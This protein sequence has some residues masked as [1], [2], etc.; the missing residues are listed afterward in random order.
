[1]VK[2]KQHHDTPMAMRLFNELCLMV[3]CDLDFRIDLRA[4]EDCNS[5][6]PIYHFELA[7]VYAQ[8]EHIQERWGMKILL[9]IPARTIEAVFANLLRSAAVL[10]V[11]CFC[12]FGFFSFRR[13]SMRQ[14]T[15][16]VG[17][18]YLFA[19]SRYEYAVNCISLSTVE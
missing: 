8:S 12:I 6:G 11:K 3:I 19:A 1:M 4:G 5:N 16:A 14:F 13:T 7:S 9:S 18:T 17:N 15:I 10:T 2:T